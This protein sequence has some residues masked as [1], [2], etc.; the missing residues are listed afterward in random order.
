MKAFIFVL[1]AIVLLIQEKNPA[2]AAEQEAQSSKAEITTQTESGAENELLKLVDG[3]KPSPTEEYLLKNFPHHI[4]VEA[5]E[6]MVKLEYFPQYHPIVDPE[7]HDRHKEFIY[8]FERIRNHKIVKQGKGDSVSLNAEEISWWRKNFLNKRIKEKKF[9][10]YQGNSYN[11]LGI[12]KVEFLSRYA[13]SMYPPDP[14]NLEKTPEVAYRKIVFYLNLDK[15]VQAD[16]RFSYHESWP[17]FKTNAKKSRKLYTNLPLWLVHKDV[18][19]KKQ[20][21]LPERLKD[22]K[23][24]EA[25]RTAIK[26]LW[27]TAELDESFSFYLLQSKPSEKI[28]SIAGT[29]NLCKD[30]LA[31]WNLEEL[32]PNWKQEECKQTNSRLH[33]LNRGID[34]NG[35]FSDLNFDCNGQHDFEKPLQAEHRFFWLGDINKNG[36][37]EFLLFHEKPYQH[38]IQ[39]EGGNAA[40]IYEIHNGEAIRLWSWIDDAC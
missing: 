10:D 18:Q 14:E 36:S 31:G 8:K 3:S 38:D 35:K 7:Y 29:I 34:E 37:Q 24:I 21:T 19:I 28:Y 6:K 13:E 23:K 39:Y 22:T 33:W 17:D 2:S 15:P 25:I 30:K 40:T 16:E 9:L 20:T 5:K 27:P 26:N 4:R 1:L 32:R 12:A 11:I